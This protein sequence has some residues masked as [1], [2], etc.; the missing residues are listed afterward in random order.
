M[1][2]VFVGF[3]CIASLCLFRVFFSFSSSTDLLR[4]CFA[5]LRSLLGLFSCL[6]RVELPTR[7]SMYRICL[8]AIDV[9]FPIFFIVSLLVISAISIGLLLGVMLGRDLWV[10]DV[11]IILAFASKRKV[12]AWG[13]QPSVSR[14]KC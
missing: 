1:Y 4:A 13:S 2:F 6:H 11:S 8:H 5:T 9:Y 3:P 10:V 7:P 14:N 12:L